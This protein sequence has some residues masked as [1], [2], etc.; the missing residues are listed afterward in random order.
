MRSTVNHYLLNE[1][2]YTY[3]K[4]SIFIFIEQKSSKMDLLRVLL[5]NFKLYYL[6]HI[7]RVPRQ[8]STFPYWL[9]G[10]DT[11]LRTR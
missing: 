5:A 2:T 4:I 3:Y 10:V 11:G 1:Y 8:C 9:L 6:A 7:R